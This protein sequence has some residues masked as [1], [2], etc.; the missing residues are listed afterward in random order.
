MSGPFALI[1]EKRCASGE[2]V[3]PLSGVLILIL[4]GRFAGFFRMIHGVIHR[5]RRN[6]LAQ[7][8]GKQITLL[9]LMDQWRRSNHYGFGRDR[10]VHLLDDR[11]YG[12][13]RNDRSDRRGHIGL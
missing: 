5:Y 10:K 9:G 12:L 13:G 11:S 4:G 6:M 8:R 7:R 3:V 2:L 1:A